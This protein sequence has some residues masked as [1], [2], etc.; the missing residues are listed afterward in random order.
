MLKK[1]LFSPARPRHAK[2]CL[3]PCGV[4]DIRD[5]Y[6]VKRRSFLDSFGRFTFHPS[7]TTRKALVLHGEWG[8]KGD[9]LS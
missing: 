2:T 8:R 4:L 3:F 9:R 6:L 7:R 1:S 5:A